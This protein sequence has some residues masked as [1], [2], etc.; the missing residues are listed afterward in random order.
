MFGGREPRAAQPLAADRRVTRG[1]LSGHLQHFRG[2]SPAAAFGRYVV[3]TVVDLYG[4]VSDD[5]A[6]LARV[7]HGLE[8]GAAALERIAAH[9]RRGCD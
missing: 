5:T 4:E 2:E 8:N 1:N 7:A 9:L 3:A 6:N